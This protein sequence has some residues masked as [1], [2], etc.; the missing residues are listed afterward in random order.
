MN[1]A[2]S[3][4]QALEQKQITREQLPL[5]LF[6]KLGEPKNELQQNLVQEIIKKIVSYYFIPE[7]DKNYTICSVIGGVSEIIQ[8][9]RKEGP[10]K[11]QNFYVLVLGS[12]DKLHAYQENLKEEQWSQITKLAL[13]GQNLVFQYRKWITNKQILD[14]YP[15][16]QNKQK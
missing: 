11:G 3:L 7:Q 9:Q 16:Q 1:Q 14:W 6:K 8:K 2:T 5:T 10:K 15:A 12:K 13:L 4:W